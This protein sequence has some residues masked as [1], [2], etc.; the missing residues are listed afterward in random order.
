MNECLYINN[1]QPSI[2]LICIQV[3]KTTNISIAIEN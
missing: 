1:K 3:G 2:T